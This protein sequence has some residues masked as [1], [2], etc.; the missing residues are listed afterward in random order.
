MLL[1][2]RSDLCRVQAQFD[3]G[4]LITQRESVSQKVSQE[5]VAR[6]S[7]FGVI[8]D[9]ISIVS[10]LRIFYVNKNLIEHNRFCLLYT[11]RCV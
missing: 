10:F 11:S 6:A 8:L 5:L 7:Q 2:L 9:D 1:L 3:A 4:E